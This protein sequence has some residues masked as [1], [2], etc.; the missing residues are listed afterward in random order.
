MNHSIRSR[1]LMAV[2]AAGA[3][4]AAAT[5]NAATGIYLSSGPAPVYVQ[6]QPVYP[7]RIVERHRP[8]YY[9]QG[10]RYE[11][12]EDRGWH[13]GC[14]APRWNPDVRYMPGATVWR[15]GSLYV[16]TGVSSSV[17]NVNSPPEWTPNYWAPATCR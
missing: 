15:N 13:H 14:R 16:A 9:A 3:V 4:G 1:I 5:A 11:R 17:W 2:V 7:A 8:E 10:E 6:T 12:Y